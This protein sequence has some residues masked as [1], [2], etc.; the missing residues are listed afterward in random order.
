MTE[1][2]KDIEVITLDDSDD[3]STKPEITQPKADKKKR[4][5]HS[6]RSISSNMKRTFDDEALDSSD[7]DNVSYF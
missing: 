3:E 5:K 1:E 2:K 6:Q 7:D 4:K